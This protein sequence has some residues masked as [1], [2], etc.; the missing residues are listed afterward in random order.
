VWE[1]FA[2]HGGVAP[3]RGIAAA[4]GQFREIDRAGLRMVGESGGGALRV[5]RRCRVERRGMSPAAHDEDAARPRTRARVD[6]GIVTTATGGTITPAIIVAMVAT[7]SASIR[8]RHGFFC[9]SLMLR[10]LVPRWSA[11]APYGAALELDGVRPHAVHFEV[12][13]VGCG[14]VAEHSGPSALVGVGDFDG[15]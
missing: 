11:Q 3:L 8:S 12:G 6:R 7:D 15:V 13:N 1:A 10:L 5:R 2:P 4:G 9:S 14:V